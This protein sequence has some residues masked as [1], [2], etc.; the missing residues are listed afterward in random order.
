MVHSNIKNSFCYFGLYQPKEVRKSYRFA[1]HVLCTT[2][3]CVNC[4]IPSPLLYCRVSQITDVLLI[5]S[6]SIPESSEN[7]NVC[8]V[9]L[10][11]F[12]GLN[13]NEILCPPKWDNFKFACQLC[14]YFRHTIISNRKVLNF[15]P[16]FWRDI[17]CKLFVCKLLFYIFVRKDKAWIMSAHSKI[18]HICITSISLWEWKLFF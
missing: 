2:K 18:A 11:Q 5:A 6:S 15:C 12:I 17:V 10:F 1:T 4:S 8:T 7:K 14:I 3:T 9:T 13:L 16:S